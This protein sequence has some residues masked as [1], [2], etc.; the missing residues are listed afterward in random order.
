MKSTKNVIRISKFHQ[1]VGYKINI[2]N[3]V[4]FLHT[5]N[6]QKLKILHSSII[7]SWGKY[8]KRYKTY[9]LKPVEHW[10]LK[11][12]MELHHASDDNIV[13]GHWF[14]TLV[15]K[16]YAVFLVEFMSLKEQKCKE[17]RRSKT[18]FK[19]EMQYFNTH[20]ACLKICFKTLV[21]KCKI[22]IKMSRWKNRRE[23]RNK[24]IYLS[25][26]KFEKE[27]KWTKDSFSGIVVE[28]LD[29]YMQKE[30]KM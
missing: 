20:I 14:N 7:L 17:P 23:F 1:H 24:H 29:T 18:T 4:V 21:I 11:R 6:Y 9:V 27:I 16:I 30:N 28:K 22:G 5:N 12:Q 10:T 15:I 2:Q 8:Y 13:D 25:F 26:I 19:N 3:S